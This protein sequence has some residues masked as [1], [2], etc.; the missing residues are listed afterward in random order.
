MPWERDGRVALLEIGQAWASSPGG[1][2][3][4]YSF[5]SVC[6]L[7]QIYCPPR[8]YVAAIPCVRAGFHAHANSC[9]RRCADTGHW[10]AGVNPCKLYAAQKCID[11]GSISHL[12]PASTTRGGRLHWRSA[13]CTHLTAEKSTP[14]SHL[15]LHRADLQNLMICSKS[16]CC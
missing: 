11:I 7:R 5:I 16:F 2:A 12:Q 3:C 8:E 9:K 14:K 6:S 15:S 4:A 10:A 1:A 13:W